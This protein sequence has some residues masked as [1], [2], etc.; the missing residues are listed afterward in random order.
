MVGELF[1]VE[2]DCAGDVLV[3]VA[4]VGVYGGRDAYGR[5]SGVEDDGVGVL[6]ASG[7]PCRGD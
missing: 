7:Q 4:G 6:E 2:E 3:E 5:E 1:D